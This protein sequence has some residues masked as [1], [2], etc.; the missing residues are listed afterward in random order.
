[1]MRQR[2]LSLE[3]LS[4]DSTESSNSNSNS[5]PNVHSGQSRPTSAPQHPQQQPQSKQQQQQ[6]QQQQVRLNLCPL[7]QLLVGLGQLAGHRGLGLV[8]LISP[9]LAMMRASVAAALGEQCCLP[10][11]ALDNLSKARACSTQA[12]FQE[13]W[14]DHRGGHIKCLNCYIK[15]I[16]K[17]RAMLRTI[18]CPEQQTRHGLVLPRKSMPGPDRRQRSWHRICHRLRAPA[19]ILG[20]RLDSNLDPLRAG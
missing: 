11:T 2:S 4:W 16:Q 9:Y 5:N 15:A 12:S 7:L 1:M 8:A 20:L 10:P 18:T 6:Q 13:S 3:H 17:L 14:G 19:K